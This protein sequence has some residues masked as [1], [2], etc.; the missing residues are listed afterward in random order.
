MTH[1]IQLI[2]I[3]KLSKNFTWTSIKEMVNLAR[4]NNKSKGITGLL[5]MQ[6]YQAM[7]VLEGNNLEVTQL[8]AKICS[9]IRHSHIEIV[10]VNQ[11]T[12]RHFDIWKMKELSLDRLINAKQGWISKF[13]N[14]EKDQPLFP[15]DYESAVTLLKVMYA[16]TKET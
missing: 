11:I 4:E 9:D 14:H 7:Q 8:F 12:E 2:Y 1:E 13:L 5:L 6:Q 16:L 3:S 10:S 15:S